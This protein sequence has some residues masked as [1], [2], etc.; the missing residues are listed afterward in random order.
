MS[1]EAQSIATN[2]LKFKMRWSPKKKKSGNGDDSVDDDDGGSNAIAGADYVGKRPPAGLQDDGQGADPG[3]TSVSP[4]SGAIASLPRFNGEYTMWLLLEDER[5]GDKLVS[6]YGFED[7][8]DAVSQEWNQVV[9]ARWDVQVT[10]KPAFEV[11]SYTRASDDEQYPPAEYLTEA[12]PTLAC[13]VGETYKIAPI[14]LRTLQT[15][16]AAHGS[17]GS[18][19][20]SADDGGGGKNDGK[21]REQQVQ[22]TLVGAPPG[23]FVSADTGEV[24]A[25]PKVPTGNGGGEFVNAE[26]YAVDASG[27]KALVETIR[28]S[29]QIRDTADPFNGPNGAGCMYGDPV[30]EVPFD[31]A[32]ACDCSVTKFRGDNCETEMANSGKVAG[33]L[34]GTLL[35][36]LVFGTAAYKYRIKQISLRAFDFQ[37]H[38]EELMAMG[39]IETDENSL[40]PRIPRE[41]R[42]A[43]VTLTEIVG[44]GAFGQVWKA[45][46]DELS[47]GGVQIPSYSVA[48]KTALDATGEGAD[49]LRREALV[50]SQVRGHPNV[51]ALIGVVTS[52]LPLMLLLSLCENGSL[53]SCLKSGNCPGQNQRPLTAPPASVCAKM[54]VQI[55]NGMHHLVKAK[56]VHRDLAARNILLDSQF[57]CKIADFGLSRG[58]A[59][60]NPDDENAQEYYTSHGGTFPVRW[61]APEAMEH[62]RFS[63]STDIW[64]FGIVLLEIVTG[65]QRPY[66]ELATNEVVITQVMGGYRAAKPERG[67]TPELYGVMLQCWEQIPTNRPSFEQLAAMLDQQL[68]DLGGGGGD[69]GGGVGGGGGGGGGSAVEY[70]MVGDSN[71]ADDQE[72]AEAQPR[73]SQ[74]S[75]NVQNIYL[76]LGGGGSGVGSAHQLENDDASM[77]APMLI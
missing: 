63:T 41:I 20:S 4:T 18:S 12:S 16:H 56:F 17:G 47:V 26:L 61:T 27:A 43:H 22:F 11:T 39:E 13:V 65:G 40:G 19:S 77:M 2:N 67:C 75:E 14:D 42:R 25:V 48:V 76:D 28:I 32:F 5:G 44:A 8:D 51:V 30:D 52:G 46:L 57:E 45:V 9:V 66:T 37:K 68:R 21:S 50:M 23:F 7:G 36:V 74:P 72:G 49:E 38:L 53:Q 35:I 29:V 33:G 34:I 6:E 55:A 64:S 10:G 73:V 58:V 71:A 24:L 3:G 69:G 1:D 70:S 59:A 62:M 54:A 31:N 60:S 15:I